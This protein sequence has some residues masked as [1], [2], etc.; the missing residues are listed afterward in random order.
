[1]SQNWK[2]AVKRDVA[3]LKGD[4]T[5]EEVRKK[6]GKRGYALVEVEGQPFTVVTAKVLADLS[7]GDTLKEVASSLPLL[8]V[9]YQSPDLSTA[10]LAQQAEKVM[11][12][13]PNLA[14]IVVMDEK[15]A[16]T[17][18]ILRRED[19]VNWI[20]AGMILPSSRMEKDKPTYGD[21]LL[22]GTPELP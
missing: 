14:G 4:G 10:S 1:M 19:L 8:M 22:P 5:V 2:D 13:H 12:E 20:A 9:V 21:A 11:L 15:G 3:R 6:L 16:E 17:E 18:G 7:P